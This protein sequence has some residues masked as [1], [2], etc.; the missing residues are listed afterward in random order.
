MHGICCIDRSS[1]PGDVQIHC[2]RSLYRMGL[3]FRVAKIS[4]MFWGYL[5]F[6]IFLF[7][8]GGGGGGGGEG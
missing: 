2:I 4:I 6:L 5:K 3:F 7:F 1:G 8:F